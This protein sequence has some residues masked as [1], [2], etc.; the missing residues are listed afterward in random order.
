MILYSQDSCP[1]SLNQG[2]ESPSYYSI[3]VFRLK[4]DLVESELT[5][6]LSIYPRNHP[7][8]AEF[9]S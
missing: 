5:K 1:Y 3:H 6:C 9:T 4:S 7:L 2:Q 8:P